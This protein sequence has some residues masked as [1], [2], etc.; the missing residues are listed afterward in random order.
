[1]E[2]ICDA[3]LLTE[4]LQLSATPAADSAQKSG[5][6]DFWLEFDARVELLPELTGKATS[7]QEVGLNTL[8]ALFVAVPWGAT[9]PALQ[10]QCLGVRPAFAHT[11]IGDTLWAQCW[12]D[13]QGRM[14]HRASQTPTWSRT[15]CSTS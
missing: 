10:L 12:G 5:M 4:E 6:D 1:M 13:R 11:M 7:E 8:A 14:M 9:L 2:K 3:E 15:R